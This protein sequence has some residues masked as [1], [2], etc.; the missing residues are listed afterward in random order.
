M[1][2]FSLA[3]LLVVLLGLST[4]A[5]S[6]H[7]SIWVAGFGNDQTID[8]HLR[9]VGRPISIQQLRDDFNGYTAS[10]SDDDKATFQA[11]RSDPSVGFLV[12]VPQDYF[13][14]F[15]ELLAAG[16]DE[17]D[18]EIYEARLRPSYQWIKLQHRDPKTIKGIN[19]GR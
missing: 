12:K 11:I 14:K 16:P 4:F 8:D 19:C 13:R 17:E 6:C 18:D 2:L 15:D 10:I 9:I 1:F 5:H 3:Y 7:P